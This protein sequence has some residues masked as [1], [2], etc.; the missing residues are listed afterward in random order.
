MKGTKFF[1]LT[2]L[3]CGL[4]LLYPYGD[5]PSLIKVPK[6]QVLVL[7]VLQRFGIDVV[8][9]LETCY[10]ALAG[11]EDAANL[12]ANGIRFSVLSRAARATPYV[13]IPAPSPRILEILRQRGRTVS[14]EPKTILFWAESG[15]TLGALP[16]DLPRKPLSQNSLLAYLR[17]AAA[18]SRS[19]SFVTTKDS[20]IEFIAAQISEANLRAQVDILQAF[21]TRFASTAACEDA[22]QYI[23]GYLQG[24]GLDDVRFQPFTFAGAYGSRNVIAEKTGETFPE[25]ILIICA[26]YDSTS[27]A[28]TRTTQ[29]PGADDN[30]SGTAAVLETARIL[31]S[32]PLDF[33]V[34]FIA[35]SAEEWGLFGSR[36]YAQEARLAGEKIIGVINLDMIA[37]ADAMPEDLTLIVNGVSGWLAGRFGQAAETYSGLA[38][39]PIVNAS[40]TYSDHASFWDMGYPALLA[41]EDEPL[42]NPYYHTTS[43]RT[44]TL[45]FSFF[46]DATRSALALVS[47]LAQPVK[48]GYPRTPTG[49]T[50]TPF[51]YSSLFNAV[52]LVRLSW[53][54]QTDAAGY[55]IYRTNMSHL[56]YQKMNASAV[57]GISFTDTGLKT[58]VPYFYVI[59]VVGDSGLESNFSLEV[60]IAPDRPIFRSKTQG[61]T[62]LRAGDGR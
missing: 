61:S 9:E 53:P 47:E 10:I 26:H 37:Y 46:S 12:R 15:D 29:A 50:A 17:R 19:G 4:L 2:F 54:G 49:L 40:F 34:R 42:A 16:P 27:G 39:S 20:L 62:S 14:V 22:G 44:N 55:N 7:D 24:L 56:D 5:N 51:V 3:V 31:A 48:T 1:A 36:S 32:F 38:S 13:L 6:N 57:T 30:A 45:N 33:T 11:R 60:E 58:D 18:P 8:Q 28:S 41:I 25:A 35:F 21:Q 52:K 43:D 23:Y 59:T